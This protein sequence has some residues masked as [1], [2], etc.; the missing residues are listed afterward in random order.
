MTED[1]TKLN[2]AIKE[3]KFGDF[4]KLKPGDF[5]RHGFVSAAGWVEE[6]WQKYRDNLPPA[7]DGS[8]TPP[9]ETT[10]K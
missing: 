6:L 10:W 7:T 5:G 9:A 8:T 1:D 3:A 2:D 4:N